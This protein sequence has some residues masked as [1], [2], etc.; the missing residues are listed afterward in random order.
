M[1][2][3]T[4]AALILAGIAIAISVTGIFKKPSI[5]TSE[6]MQCIQV[7]SSGSTDCNDAGAFP[8]TCAVAKCPST[9]TL[10]GGGGIC[11]AGNIKLKGVN[12]KLETG[13]FFIMCEKQGV[14]PQVN[15]ICCKL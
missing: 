14:D 7:K 4:Q 5:P 10:T 9:Y 15:A 1:E 6:T 11:A 3:Y 2:K 13:E 8:S 12:P